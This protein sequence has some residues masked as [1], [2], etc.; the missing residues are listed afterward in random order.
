MIDQIKRL[1]RVKVDSKTGTVNIGPKS[2]KLYLERGLK[3]RKVGAGI[4]LWRK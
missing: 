1:I 2:K 4:D 3:S